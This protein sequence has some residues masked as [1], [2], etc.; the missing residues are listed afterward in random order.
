MSTRQ[1]QRN[2]RGAGGWLLLT[3]K[4]P[5]EPAKR[6]IA[7]WRK[8]KGLGAI[9]LQN[10]VCV[11]PRTDAHLRRLKVLERE[12]AEMGGEAILL[13]TASLDRAQEDKVL[14]RFAAERDEA[15]VEFISRC[16]DFEG[17][18]SRER[19]ASKFTYAEVE[20][21]EEDLAK[22][23]SWLDKIVRLDFFGAPLRDEA[24]ACLEGC[25]TI[26]DD[27]A[28]DVFELQDENRQSET[29]EPPRRRRSGS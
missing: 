7:L 28:R 24:R 20:E 10:G 26:L 14:A 11:L 21:N 22:L 4:V 23:R 15:Y 27:Y 8:L 25:A 5:P 3:Y 12:I 6:R 18:I 17:E 16:S 9:Y 2:S 29:A 1:R 19:A 13:K